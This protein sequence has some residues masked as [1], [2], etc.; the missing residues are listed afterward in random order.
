MAL[1]S[2]PWMVGGGAEHS[3]HV[4]RTLAYLASGG[5]EGVAAATDCKVSATGTPSAAVTVAPGVVAILNKY[6][7]QTKQTYVGRVVS[8]TSVSITPTGGAAR[9]DMVVLRI[10]DPNFGGTVPANASSGPYLKL[11]VITDVGAG[12][13]TVPSGLGYP[14][15]PL[16]RIDLPA[17][18]AT[19]TSGMIVDLRELAQP[20]SSRRIFMPSVIG[21]SN[22]IDTTST[23][24]KTWANADFN[25]AIP[26]WATKM[27]VV[28]TV[29]GVRIGNGP[30]GK[31]WVRF[32]GSNGD[33][34][35]FDAADNA[36][37]SR[38]TMV[39]AHEF[40]ISSAQRGTSKSIGMR[41]FLTS[42]ND[43]GSGR[44]LADL[45]TVVLYDIEFVEDPQA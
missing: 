23:A 7:G 14:A 35:A 45:G 32:D 36:G 37:F 10:D 26:D 33:Q 27:R 41:A 8:N 31:F 21:D 39:D 28:A 44:P 18:T 34:S 15:V 2:V 11:A 24:G 9:S 30:I 13:K 22:Y 5:G 4:G 12:A 38:T 25:I 1:E 42:G 29:S 43:K 17:S 19:V 40:P 3:E 6:A 20:K 16:A